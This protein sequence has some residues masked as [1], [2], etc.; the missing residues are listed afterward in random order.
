MILSSFAVS[1]QAVELNEYEVSNEYKSGIFYKTVSEYELTG[2]QRYDVV[3]IALTQLGYEEGDDDSGM[4][5]TSGGSR[6]FV[7]YNRLYGK[8][9][10][11]EGNGYSYGYYWCASFVNWV[12]RA[13]DVEHRVSGGEVSCASWVYWFQSNGTY[14]ERTSGYTPVCGDIIFYKGSRTNAIS[15]HVGIVVGYEDG[16]VYTI[17]GNTTGIEGGADRTNG[18]QVARKCYNKN[19]TY[20]VGY[21]VPGYRVKEGTNY[22]FELI[23]LSAV[24]AGDYTVT[25]RSAALYRNTSLT[26][27]L[28]SIPSGTTITI[29]QINGNFGKCTYDGAEGW[30][31]LDGLIDA[32]GAFHT[33]TYNTLGGGEVSSQE[34]AY[35][36]NIKIFSNE[37]EKA[38]NTFKGWAIKEG[39]NVVYQPGDTYIYDTDVTLYAVYEPLQYTITFK[40]DD[41]TILS[42][43]KYFYGDTVMIP[44]LSQE[45]ERDDG[46]VLVWDSEIVPVDGDKTYTASFVPAESENTGDP[47]ENTGSAVVPLALIITLAVVVILAVA[48][49]VFALLYKK[50]EKK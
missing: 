20:I 19:D 47:S 38:G 7:E 9:D 28:K 25:G 42:E 26:T 31:S 29:T 23:D 45:S 24:K 3:S 40:M 27:K 32:E 34:K 39:G 15:N 35:G 11:G 44:S 13:A 21:G 5:G 36:K 37:P 6:N 18:G 33:V 8:L 16:I 12:L 30:V 1:A 49:I 41:G 46:F 48:A 4:H 43:E 22:D 2:D 10:N 14:K 17:E 50:P